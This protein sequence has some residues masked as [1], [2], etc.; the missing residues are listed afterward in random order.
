MSLAEKLKRA[1]SYFVEMPEQPIPVSEEAGEAETPV[2]PPAPSEPPPASPPEPLPTPAPL[3]VS[4]AEAAFDAA[5]AAV[6]KAQAEAEA[7]VRTGT[8]R[9]VEQ[10]VRESDGPNLDE[11]TVAFEERVPLTPEGVLDF[12]NIYAQAGLPAPPFTA[13]QMMAML[14]DLPVEMPIEMKRKTVDVTLAA[15]GKHIGASPETIV[16]DAS[17][18]LAALAAY[19]KEAETHTQE[20]VAATEAEIAALLAQV[21]EKRRHVL[22]ATERLAA[23]QQQCEGE[24][25]RLD[26]VLDFFSTNPVKASASSPDGLPPPLPP[27]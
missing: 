24:A 16:A 8:P 1:A 21:E 14:H 13:E 27:R 26:D 2:E 12:A 7:Q 3:P 10:I 18:K 9:T 15:M 17:R 6:E 19:E 11:I 22:S 25:D 4:S 20:Q 5:I 23:I